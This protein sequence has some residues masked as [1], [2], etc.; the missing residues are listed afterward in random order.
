MA[1]AAT[2]GQ[3]FRFPL[4]HRPRAVTVRAADPAAFDLR[5]S[6]GALVVR[7]TTDAVWHGVDIDDHN[8]LA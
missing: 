8:V 6:G 2:A 3:E 4:A 7:A 1:L 5:W